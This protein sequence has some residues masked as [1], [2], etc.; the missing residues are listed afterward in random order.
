[1]G[2]AVA[3]GV[4]DIGR[5]PD[6]VRH[7]EIH[8]EIAEEDGSDLVNSRGKGVGAFVVAVER[9]YG[10]PRSVDVDV[11]LSLLRHWGPS[12]RVDRY[13][14]EG[15]RQRVLHPDVTDVEWPCALGV[16]VP[17]DGTSDGHLSRA[18]SF[19]RSDLTTVTCCWL[20][21]KCLLTGPDEFDEIFDTHRFGVRDRHDDRRHGSV[22]LHRARSSSPRR[23][24]DLAGLS[25]VED[26]SRLPPD[27]VRC[28][29]E[30]GVVGCELG[31]CQAATEFEIRR[32]R[33]ARVAAVAADTPH[34]QHRISDQA[35]EVVAEGC[36][37]AVG[38]SYD[39]SIGAGHSRL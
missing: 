4:D 23:T 1:M 6:R 8:R 20:R 21:W 11:D 7:V 27:G 32:V 14:P 22:D 16:E 38:V 35:T 29:H 2:H 12:A 15:R 3:V 26:G 34:V 39:E 5:D 18:C 13:G 36:F 9:P 31:P 37:G 17:V 25:P 30:V 10:R 33:L 28:R 24:P 19:D